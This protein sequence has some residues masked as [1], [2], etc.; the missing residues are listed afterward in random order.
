MKKCFKKKVHPRVF[1]EWKLVLK[2]ILLPHLDSRGKWIP[3]YE[4][5]YVFKTTFSG[6]GLILKIMAGEGLPY[7]ANSDA[8]KKDYV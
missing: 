1:K 3:N 2:K 6:G 8:V 4:G 5:S 7:Q